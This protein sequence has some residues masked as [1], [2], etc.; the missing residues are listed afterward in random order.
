[1]AIGRVAI[2]PGKVLEKPRTTK[3]QTGAYYSPPK[4]VN[5]SAA[6]YRGSQSSAGKSKFNQGTYDLQKKLK[7]QGYYK[8]RLDGISG[9]MTKAALKA[10]NNANSGKSKSSSSGGGSK[11]KAGNSSGS[12]GTVRTTET[13]VSSRGGNT[14]GGETTAKVAAAAPVEKIETDPQKLK[15]DEIKRILGLDSIY[16][17]EEAE[18]NNIFDK[19]KDSQTRQTTEYGQNYGINQRNIADNRDKAY[20]NNNEGYAARGMFHSGGLM[21]DF[22]FLTKQYDQQDVNLNNAKNSFEAQLAEELTA[23]AMLRDKTINS[24][25]TNAL[26][27]WSRSQ[28]AKANASVGG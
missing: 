22:D 14:G 17:Q 24:S 1:M 18:A 10:Y 19:I 9:P 27:R 25:R 20:L 16:T 21:Q 8:G 28:T 7:A 15:D 11:P 2:N 5:S 6:T 4:S 26:D 13:S 23:Q 3:T 12:R